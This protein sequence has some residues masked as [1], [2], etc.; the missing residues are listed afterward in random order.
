MQSKSNIRSTLRKKRQMGLIKKVVYTFIFILF[1]ASLAI[2]GLTT[3]QVKIK[4]IKVLGNSSISSDEIIKLSTPEVNTKYLWIIPTDNIFLLRGKEIKSAILDNFKK[5]N[6]V[7]IATQG[8]DKLKIVVTE[9]VAKDIWCKGTPVNP[10]SCYFMDVNGYIF[11]EAPTFSGNSFPKYFGLITDVS[12]I[13]QNYFTDKQFKTLS[14][15][16]S[17]LNNMNFSLTSFNAVD[18]N[19]YEAMITGGGKILLNNKSTFNQQITNLQALIDN[20]YI[21]TASSSLAKIKYID[22]RYGN[23][24]NFQLK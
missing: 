12:P 7:R 13:G 2:L 18:E 23:K 14:S 9:R 20:N 4:D 6:T 24:V 8:F 3:E 21:K 17:V 11:E 15:L 19:E 1:F 5:I 10:G 16:F 22:L